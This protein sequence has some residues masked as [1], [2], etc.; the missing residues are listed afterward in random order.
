MT[1]TIQVCIEDCTVY[2]TR[3]LLKLIEDGRGT[4]FEVV[5]G[6]GINEIP[7]QTLL[8]QLQTL[9][10]ILVSNGH[11]KEAEVLQEVYDHVHLPTDFGGLG[12]KAGKQPSSEMDAEILF[13]VSA[14]LQALNSVERAKMPAPL[15]KTRP[16]GRRGMT[17]SEKIFAA[18]DV[19]RHGS[20]K[21]G[22][23][24][25][26]NVDWIMASELSWHGMEQTYNA[27]GKP[28]IFRNDRFWLAGDHVVDPRIKDVPKVKAMVNSSVKARQVF[29]M[30]ENQ[31]MNY[32][33]M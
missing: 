19:H 4:R 5:E 2:T 22:D 18:H 28:G 17:L 12:L 6:K 29:K 30:T 20:V 8:K 31:G 10:S 7:S 27:L 21:P 23:V 15:L 24:V 9:S 32:T 14:Y 33:I 25:V 11:S 13:L 1:A 16:A 26:V 3:Q